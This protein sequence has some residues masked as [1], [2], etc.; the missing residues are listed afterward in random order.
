MIQTLLQILNILQLPAKKIQYNDRKTSH[1][2]AIQ[3]YAHAVEN[4][5]LADA[6]GHLHATLWSKS[7]M[8]S[9]IQRQE[10]QMRKNSSY[11]HYNFIYE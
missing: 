9:R 3:W 5:M 1:T 8:V 10:K 11:V 6:D 2:S 4:K 7:T